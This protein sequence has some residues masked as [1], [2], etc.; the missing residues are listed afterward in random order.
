MIESPRAR[1]VAQTLS[2]AE[3]LRLALGLLLMA[4][5]SGC[6]RPQNY[7]QEFYVWQRIW[8]PQVRTAIVQSADISQG[9]RVLAAEAREDTLLEAMAIDWEALEN[10]HRPIVAVVRID[11][12]LSLARATP[13]IA[14]LRVLA[15]QWA[16]HNVQGLEIDYDCPTAR[17][18]TYA[19]F[20]TALRATPKLPPHLSITALPAWLDAT[21]L[22]SV[23][24]LVDEVVLQVHAVRAPRFGLFDEALARRWIDALDRRTVQPFRVALPDYGARVATDADGKVVAVEAEVPRLIGGTSAE[25]L[26]ADPSAVAKLLRDLRERPPWHLKGFVWFRLPTD[27]DERIWSLSTLRA[28]LSG[29]PLAG[30]LDAV[31]TPGEFAG[32][33]DI[34]LINNGPIDL[35]LPRTIALAPGCHAADG[36]NGYGLRVTAARLSLDRLQFGLL[37]AHHR[38]IVG[39]MRCEGGP[40][41]VQIRF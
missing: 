34:V 21:A 30:R 8:S 9:W 26:M 24:A 6:E 37:P 7:T 31:A 20:L 14:Q 29:A 39:W 15:R 33:S 35:P 10:T 38:Q 36:I 19:Q 40:S 4:V 22:S 18:S 41:D 16:R 32:A 12:S 3:P 27:A 25:D 13:L 2:R 23:L 28:V 17:L 5:L 11:G 1:F